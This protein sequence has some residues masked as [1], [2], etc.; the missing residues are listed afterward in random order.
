MVS[1]SVGRECRYG[2]PGS[3]AW[4]QACW[5]QEIGWVVFSSGVLAGEKFRPEVSQV[6][7]RIHFLVT[8]SLRVHASCRVPAG[9]SS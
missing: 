1:V 8:I 5:N 4:I 2:L 7:A 3:S 9:G 6:A